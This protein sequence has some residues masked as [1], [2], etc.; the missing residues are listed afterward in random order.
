ML[1]NSVLFDKS[2]MRPKKIENKALLDGVMSVFRQKGFDGA[3][4]ND[5]AESSGLKKA[6]LYY[7]FPNGKEEL[8]INVLKYTYE[9]MEA[10]IYNTLTDKKMAPK[11]RLETVI[12]KINAFYKGGE[13]A[14]ILKS[15]SM[16]SSLA[17]FETQIKKSMDKWIAGFAVL[18][19]DLGLKTDEAEKLATRSLVL[20]QGSLIVAKGSSSKQIFKDALSEIKTSYIG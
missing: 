13:D 10:N 15:F 12:D 14:C 11:Q 17:L 6:S 4:L 19:Q 2:R 3:S 18:G 20:V 7:R 16:D 9:S 5:L 1:G 8:A